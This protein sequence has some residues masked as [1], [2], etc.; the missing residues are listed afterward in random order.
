M[1]LICNYLLI[2]YLAISMTTVGYGDFYAVT[3]P[4]RIVSAI[5]IVWGI[6]IISLLL[7]IKLKLFTKHEETWL[8]MI[9]NKTVKSK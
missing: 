7:D 4:A 1:W 8:E 2:I 3:I 6:F 5:S 9:E